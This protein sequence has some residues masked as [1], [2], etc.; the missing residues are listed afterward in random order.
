MS[1]SRTY[2]RASQRPLGD[3]RVNR[4]SYILLL[5]LLNTLGNWIECEALLGTLSRFRNVLN[6]IN[7]TG[8]RML[9]STYNMTLKSF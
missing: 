5:N 2:H 6:T 3:N 1:C 7:N 4:G 8:A 9:D